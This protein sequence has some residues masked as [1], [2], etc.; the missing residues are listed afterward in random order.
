[1]RSKPHTALTAPLVLHH[2][3]IY[4]CAMKKLGFNGRIVI[5]HSSLVK[6]AMNAARVCKLRN[7][8]KKRLNFFFFSQAKGGT[9]TIAYLTLSI[10]EG[11]NFWSLNRLIYDCKLQNERATLW[12]NWQLKNW[13]RSHTLKGDGRIF[14][15]SLRDASFNKDLSNEPNFDRIHLAGQYL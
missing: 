11:S 8:V 12:H 13:R 10:A 4:K 7:S 9:K 6:G 1:M 14:L 3:R 15:K 2:T 5:Y